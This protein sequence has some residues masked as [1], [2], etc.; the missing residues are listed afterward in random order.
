MKIHNK[1]KLKKKHEIS[2][3]IARI[4]KEITTWIFLIQ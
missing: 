1:K 3:W 2:Y 4:N